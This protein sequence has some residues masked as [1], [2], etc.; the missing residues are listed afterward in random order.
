MAA[1]TAPGRSSLAQRARPLTA[2]RTL[3]DRASALPALAEAFREH[4]FEGASLTILSQATGLGKG[5]LYNFFP[6]GKEE[7]LAAVLADIHAWFA[8]HLFDPLERSNDPRAAIRSMIEQVT[9]YFRSGQRVCLVGS[10]SLGASGGG[11]SHR[12]SAY[13]ARWITA[14]AGCLE[15]GRVAPTAARA[16]AEETVCAIQGAIILSRALGDEAIFGSIV[17]RQEKVLLD[18]MAAN[19]S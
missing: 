12:V 11:F 3:S 4:G 10:I 2:K 19:R 17:G 9:A 7:M 15:R 1:G 16:F 14:L 5:S 13:F 8:T 18:A 6:G